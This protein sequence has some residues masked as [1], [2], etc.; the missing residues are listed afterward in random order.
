LISA[1][2]CRITDVDNAYKKE[3]F[4]EIEEPIPSFRRHPLLLLFL[5]FHHSRSFRKK[6][7]AKQADVPEGHSDEELV[8]PAKA[9]RKILDA[10][11]ALARV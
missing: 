3:A 11:R 7:K 5:N 10:R 8:H 9:L 1:S 4:A 2:F 6:T